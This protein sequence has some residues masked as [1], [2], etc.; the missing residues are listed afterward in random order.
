MRRPAAGP[1][2]IQR[3]VAGL[4]QMGGEEIPIDRSR[5]VPIVKDKAWIGDMREAL[6]ARGAQQPLEQVFDE[7]NAELVVVYAEDNPKSIR[8]LTPKQFEDL[9][10]PREGL[11]ELAIENLKRLLPAI[12]VRSGP[13]VSMVMAGGDYEASLLL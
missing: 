11:R 8:Y 2:I 7:L 9:G 3:Y 5:I 13:L 12:E 10:I 1:E 6:K 4:S